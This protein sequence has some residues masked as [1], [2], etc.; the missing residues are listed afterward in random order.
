MAEQ[1]KVTGITLSVYP[2]GENDR[3]LTILTKERGKI[4]VFARG[5]RRPTHPLFGVTAPL[6][7]CEY[8]ITEGR[9]YDY[10]NSAVCKDYFKEIKK[11]LEDIYYST[12]FA[13]VVS[14]FTMEGQ[15]ARDVLNLLYVTF[16]A[17]RKKLLSNQVI[18]RIFELKIMQFNGIGMGVTSCLNCGREDHLSVLSLRDGG[19]YCSDCGRQIHDGRPIDWRVRKALWYISVVPLSRLYA[20]S[21]EEEVFT[22]LSWIVKQFMRLHLEHTFPAAKML[23]MFE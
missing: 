19:V 20:F 16:A 7:Y 23:S 12:Y 14:Y 11:D 22:E 3:R 17:M 10:L 2:I 13:E 4:Q 15:D 9:R 18:R 1:T 8:M 6:I 5:C 21:M